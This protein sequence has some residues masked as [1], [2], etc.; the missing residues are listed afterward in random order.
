MHKE[1]PR[2]EFLAR[3]AERKCGSGDI[4]YHRLAAKEFIAFD[5]AMVD[6]INSTASDDAGPQEPQPAYPREVREERD[7]IISIVRDRLG[8]ALRAARNNHS[9]IEVSGAFLTVAGEMQVV[10]DAI[11]AS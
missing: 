4:E 5:D 9:N 6:Y 1:D 11:E 10:L 2:I 3:A 7:R 8:E